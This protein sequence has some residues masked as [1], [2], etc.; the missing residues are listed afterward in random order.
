MRAAW[1]AASQIPNCFPS[2]EQII[3]PGAVQDEEDPV[4]PPEAGV[5]GAGGAPE[6][7]A[8]APPEGAAAAAEGEA[9]AVGEPPEAGAEPLLDGEG[10][11]DA[12]I[13]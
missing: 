3:W 6:L 11:P 9:R 8:A 2:A 10:A 7:G 4:E 12:R 5:A 1:P 13:V